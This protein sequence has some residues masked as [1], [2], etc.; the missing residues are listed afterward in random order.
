MS[1]RSHHGVSSQRV[2]TNSAS[3]K[4]RKM[5]PRCGAVT[6]V[7]T[8]SR[9]SRHT[10]QRN[11]FGRN[12]SLRIHG[13]C[14]QKRYRQGA[15]RDRLAEDGTGW[16]GGTGGRKVRVFQNSS[17]HAAPT[18]RRTER[19][20]AS[21]K[22]CDAMRRRRRR[23]M[24]D[25]SSR[26]PEAGPA[27]TVLDSL[28]RSLR[29]FT[30]VTSYRRPLAVPSRQLARLRERRTYADDTVLRIRPRWVSRTTGCCV[31]PSGLATTSVVRPQCPTPAAHAATAARPPARRP[32]PRQRQTT[33]CRACFRFW[34]PRRHTLQRA[35]RRGSRRA[36]S[37]SRRPGCSGPPPRR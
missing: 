5:V 8:V 32:T 26:L 36:G 19:S 34:L 11:T 7:S 27:V 3:R 21:A 37:G 18:R 33:S 24:A 20:C 17:A 4:V 6:Q 28:G 2:A 1:S 25:I 31:R 35:P 23:A 16:A 13:E 12:L 30:C 10:R 22:S 9:T 15:L 14:Y 29:P